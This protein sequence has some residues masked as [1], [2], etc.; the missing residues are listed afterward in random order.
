MS[1]MNLENG[2]GRTPRVYRSSVIRASDRCTQKV[3]LSIHVGNSYFFFVP[4]SSYDQYYIILI[5]FVLTVAGPT[6]CNVCDAQDAGTCSLRQGNQTCATDRES[7]GTTHCG[8]AAIKYLRFGD[9]IEQG[10]IR[11]CFDCTGKLTNLFELTPF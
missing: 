4:W 8:S 10:I 9:V 1:H 3:I 6:Q 7:L 11:G 5:I 2:L